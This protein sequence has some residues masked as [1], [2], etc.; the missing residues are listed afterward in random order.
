MLVLQFGDGPVP[1]EYGEL[2]RQAA[3][4]AQVESAIADFAPAITMRLQSE[5]PSRER[6]PRNFLAKLDLGA[7]AAENEMADLSDYYLETD[8]YRRASRGEAQIVAGRKGAGKTALFVAL[9]NSLRRNRQTVVLDLKPEGFQLLKFKDIVLTYLEQGTREHTTIAF[10]EYLLLLEICHKILEKDKEYH[11]TNHR[12][13]DQYRAMAAQYK[14]DEYVS[15]GDFAER[16]L[17]LGLPHEKWTR[18]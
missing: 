13:T 9:R 17:K 5:S 4:I 8:E 15:E 14:A 10:W 6:Q 11:I 12:L 3:T 7:T 16:M 18:G 2:A 1:P